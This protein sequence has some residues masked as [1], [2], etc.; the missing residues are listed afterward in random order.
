M[1]WRRV[2]PVAALVLVIVALLVLGLALGL[3]HSASPPPALPN[4]NGYVE[5]LKAAQHLTPDSE[6][7]EMGEDKLRAFLN[8]N[9][10]SLGQ[11]KTALLHDCRVPLNY[12]ATNSSFLQDLSALK[13]VAQILR[14]KGKLEEHDQHLADAA[15]TYSDIVRLGCEV[16]RGGRIIESLVG[17]AIE[18][19]GTARLESLASGPGRGAVAARGGVAGSRGR[20]KSLCCRGHSAGT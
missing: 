19:I 20:S 14:E 6:I 2:R 13:R 1:F 8:A 17:M 3:S 5:L 12:S 15:A 4:P 10:D 11:V 16:S 9:A 18:A 7:S